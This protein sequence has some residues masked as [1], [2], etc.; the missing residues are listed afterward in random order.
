M[1]GVAYTVSA[2]EST[3]SVET[4]KQAGGDRGAPNP[5]LQ[6]SGGPA[7][8]KVRLIFDSLLNEGETALDPWLAKEYTVEDN[9]YTFKLNENALW[10]DGEPV[11]AHDVVF[12][13]NYYQEHTPV[14]QLITSGDYNI[15]KQLLWMITRYRLLLLRT[16]L[17]HLPLL[18]LCI[19]SRN[20][21]GLK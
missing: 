9:V 12:T 20:I 13:V 14:T 19:L 18:V 7:D 11:T 5:F 8:Q 2:E 17:L 1:N 3:Y 15:L 4:L 10:H 21:S 16:M 6:K